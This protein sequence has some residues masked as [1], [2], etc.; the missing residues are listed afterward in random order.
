MSYKQLAKHWQ[1]TTLL[2]PLLGVIGL[3]SPPANAQLK[4]N[5]TIQIKGLDSL[6]GQVCLSVFS[7]SQG[8]PDGGDKNTRRRCLKVTEEETSVSFPNLPAGSYAIAVYHDQNND[9]KLNRDSTGI[10]LEGYGFSNNPIIRT[11]PPKY[12]SCV[13]LV[14]GPDTE[15]TIRMRY[16][17]GG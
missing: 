11:G 4:G 15:I 2:L 16:G 17:T 9:N 6:Q 14:A 7:S 5:L 12:G 8:F 13:V 10:P 3:F 1:L